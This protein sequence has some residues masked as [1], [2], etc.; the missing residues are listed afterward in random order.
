MNKLLL[1]LF[2]FVFPALAMQENKIASNIKITNVYLDKRLNLYAIEAKN[3]QTLCG[4]ITFKYNPQNK[5]IGHI[6]N[7]DVLP[8]YRKNGIGYQLFRKAIIELKKQGYQKITWL[9]WSLNEEPIPSSTLIKIYESMAQ[10]LAR[11]IKCDL[12]TTPSEYDPE[13]TFFTLTLT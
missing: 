4:S 8:D 2:I 9:G 13:E 11:E 5:H 1:F 3:H 10:K 12:E 6:Y 7:L